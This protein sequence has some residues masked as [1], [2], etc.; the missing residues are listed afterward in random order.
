MLAGLL[1]S[2]PMGFYAPAQLVRDAKEHGVVVRPVDVTISDWK[3]A[4]EEPTQ[5][6]ANPRWDASFEEPIR[7]V[8]LGMAQVIGMREAAAMRIV[9]AR[10]VGPFTSVEDLARRAQLDAHDLR[11]LSGADAL[12]SL[13]GHRP[14]AVWEAVGV[15]TRPTKLLKDAPTFEEHTELRAPTEG[16]DIVDDYASTGLTLR[17]HPLALLRPQ[18]SR[19]GIRTAE[20]LRQTAK[21]RDQVRASGIVTHRQQPSTASGVI[22]ATLEDETGTV[23]IIVWP[24][25]AAAQRQALRGSMLLSVQGTWQAEKGVYS[26]VAQKLVNHAQL[27]GRLRATSRDFR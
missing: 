10:E 9:Q 16:A 20:E 22:F 17:R 15:E 4:L 12:R 11:C 27:L 26:L 2:Q 7:A 6:E 14:N 3:S 24:S 5:G 8:R 25:V 18:L 1:N 13:A 23:N 19:M 21:D